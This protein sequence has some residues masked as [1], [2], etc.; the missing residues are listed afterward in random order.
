[1]R[2]AIRSRCPTFLGALAVA[3]ALVLGTAPAEAQ[4]LGFIDAFAESIVSSS[5]PRWTGPRVPWPEPGQRPEAVGVLASTFHPV[6]VHVA[7]PRVEVAH[8]AEALVALERAHAWL[9][10]HGWPTPPSDGGRGGTVGFDLYLVD[11]LE[12][13][14]YEDRP[15]RPAFVREDYDTPNLG[16]ALDGT[17][18][19]ARASLAEVHPARLE[20][21]VTA[22]YAR[23]GLLAFDPS[24]A[25]AWRA[26][27][28]DYVA[29]LATGYFG[30]S[31]GPIVAQQRQS[32]RT[33]IGDDPDGGGGA[34]FLA[35]LS[36]RTDGLT[37]SFIR[38]LWSGAP[39][40][41]WEGEG[42]RAVPDLWQVVQAVMEAGRDPLP[43]L[44]E[45]L[46]VARYFAG[47]P[48]R[49]RGAPVG[50][51]R[52]L[53]SEARVPVAARV[54]WARLP[55]R[56]DPDGLELAPLGS[57][58]L[59]VDTAGAP[60]GSA[61]R[62]W[63]QGEL[64][65][66]WALTAVRIGPDGEERGRVRAPV[67]PR[68]PRSYIPLELPYGQTAQVVIV[69]TNMGS[70]LVDADGPNDQLRSFRVVLDKTEP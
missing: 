22:A 26:A 46:A 60:P 9:E 40:V 5:A 51:L 16:S 35:L 58:Y 47:D 44:I 12:E 28:A 56:F 14:P 67:R 38:D 43:R 27:T 65:V 23:A 15:P 49:L 42:L 31:D 63:L 50:V 36:A 37:G 45:E 55:R 24:E 32:E 18:T 17:L 6:H 59:V 69:V 1:M 4:D 70:R 20:A 2:R 48:G 54:P 39:Q 41:T 61:L 68:T 62:I 8:A 64:G 53:P 66:G 21:C 25:P 34:L 33:W 11:A 30:C 3:L 13:L 57:A 10:A 19:F 29:W 7:A 52:E